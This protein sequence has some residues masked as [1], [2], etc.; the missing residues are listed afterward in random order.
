MINGP[1]W[2]RL[3]GP[4]CDRGSPWTVCLPL[5]P[6]AR[7]RE[8]LIREHHPHAPV[9]DFEVAVEVHD[10]EESSAGRRR[11]SRACG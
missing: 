6:A 4:F 3:Q 2:P 1:H 9:V 11:R 10:V 8:L 7:R 5:G